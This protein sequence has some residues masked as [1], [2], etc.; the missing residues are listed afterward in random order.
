MPQ[1]SPRSES[2][3]R[4]HGATWVKELLTSVVIAFAMAFVS[5]AFV[6]RGF[7]IP[8]SSMAPTLLG[9][10]VRITSPVSGLDWAQTPS[11]YADQFRRAPLSQQGTPSDP[12]VAHDPLAGPFG[13]GRGEVRV[14]GLGV[15]SGDRVFALRY[16]PL[17]SEPERFDP[18]VFMSPTNPAEN[19]IKRLVGLPGEQVALADGDCFV[20]PGHTGEAP[21]TNNDWQIAR[22]PERLQRTLWQP[23]YDHSR[24]GGDYLLPWTGAPEAWKLD[25]KTVRAAGVDGARLRW[26]SELWPIDDGLA[27]N[28]IELRMAGASRVFQGQ[29]YQRWQQMLRTSPRYAVS[30]LRV[31]AGIAGDAQSVRFGVS[32]RGHEFA[33]EL[34]ATGARVWMRPASGG[35]RQ[36][37]DE[38][39]GN[40]LSDRRVRNVEFWHVDQALWLFVDGRLVAGGPEKGGYSWHPARRL[41]EA[42]GLS[43]PNL[44]RVDNGLI[45]PSATDGRSPLRRGTRVFTLAEPWVEVGGGEL[46]LYR[47]RVDRDIYWRP[48]MEGR[49]RPGRLTP[50][51]A[52]HP[53]RSPALG[54]DQYFLLGDNSTDSEDGRSWGAAHPLVRDQLPHAGEGVV[55]RELVIGR[56]F[57]VYLPG[58]V[59]RG[60]APVPLAGRVRLMP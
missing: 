26:D 31:S 40:W 32:A 7:V 34:D 3:E 29:T 24:R 57:V 38:V 10:H 54:P 60:P 37:L 15:R 41:E 12:I 56:A 48:V 14:S 49:G 20:R 16:L 30:D 11:F 51:R 43:F 28:D 36:V 23:V 5:M 58:W 4:P 45:E 21:W 33:G 47:F 50:G 46:D 55:P 42:T 25:G 17:I 1:G 18:V 53:T 19:V 59:K 44:A 13:S 9:A 22:K 2:S 35:A 52:T 39:R 6:I 27:Q 8:T